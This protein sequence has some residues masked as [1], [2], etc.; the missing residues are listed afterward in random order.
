MGFPSVEPQN[1]RHR[2]ALCDHH[3]CNHSCLQ[4]N[5]TTAYHQI[6]QMWSDA[7]NVDIFIMTAPRMSIVTLYAFLISICRLLMVLRGIQEAS[8]EHC[9]LMTTEQLGS[10][11][12]TY[13][14]VREHNRVD[15]DRADV[16]CEPAAHN[17]PQDNLLP[18]IDWKIY[19]LRDSFILKWSRNE[20]YAG[21]IIQ[22]KILFFLLKRM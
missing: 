4:L 6:H 21:I 12:W 1:V 7:V 15:I 5:A 2:N 10:C 17:K 11:Y 20:M 8:R 9:M 3:S 14:R 18:A 13:V 19:R 16:H 22:Y